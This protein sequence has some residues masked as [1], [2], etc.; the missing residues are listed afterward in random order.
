M[1]HSLVFT[2]VL[3]VGLAT[4]VPLLLPVPADAASIIARDV[5]VTVGGTQGHYELNVFKPMMIANVL[6]SAHL[7]IQMLQGWLYSELPFSQP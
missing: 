6:Q 5:A 1:R 3:A 4:A 7:L 2:F